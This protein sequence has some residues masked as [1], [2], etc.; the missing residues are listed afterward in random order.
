MGERSREPESRKV[1]LRTKKEGSRERARNG[2]EAAEGL[3][4]Q[5]EGQQSTAS[6]KQLE[7][8]PMK[9]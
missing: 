4:G 9:C 8:V 5:S 1:R 2:R 3:P 6:R 7:D